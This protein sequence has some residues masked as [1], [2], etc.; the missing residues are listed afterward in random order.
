MP[1]PNDVGPPSIFRA[2]KRKPYLTLAFH[3][4]SRAV[5]KDVDDEGYGLQT[6]NVQLNE[7]RMTQIFITQQH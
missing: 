3:I 1:H 7:S 2:G 6:P 5:P 4:V